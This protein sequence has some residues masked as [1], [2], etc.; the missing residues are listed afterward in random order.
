MCFLTIFSDNFLVIAETL[1]IVIGSMLMGILLSYLH[2]GH[3]KKQVR[4]LSNSLDLERDQAEDLKIQIKIQNAIKG[5]MQNEIDDGKLKLDANGRKIFD[6]Q[7]LLFNQQE[8]LAKNELGNKSQKSAIDELHS[9]IDSY[10]HRLRV[11]EDELFLAKKAPLTI[12]KIN[13]V[14]PARA[15]Y[16]HVSQLLGRQVTENDLTLITGI[17]PK[18]ALLLE[19]NGIQT[20][21][22]L[23]KLPPDHLIK[24]LS[25]AGGIYKSL[26]PSQWPKQAMMASHGEWR[27]LRVFQE[28]LRKND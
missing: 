25:E 12:K 23:A 11:I 1:A 10:Q 18:T 14:S 19:G 8:Q 17:G 3:L 27:K 13:A 21:D 26:D 2:W 22:D 7:Q 16:E 4:K 9:T 28:T 20:W 6:Q 24:I 5:Q 15:N